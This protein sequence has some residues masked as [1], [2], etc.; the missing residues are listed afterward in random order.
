MSR[1]RVVAVGLTTL[2]IV[3]AV[4]AVARVLSNRRELE[5]FRMAGRQPNVG[6]DE[7]PAGPEV[8]ATP[9]PPAA[10]NVPQIVTRSDRAPSAAEF[11]LISVLTQ[12]GW[13][14]D[15]MDQKFGTDQEGPFVVFPTDFGPI[16]VRPYG[17]SFRAVSYGAEHKS[18]PLAAQEPGISFD[19]VIMHIREAETS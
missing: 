13:P 14:T 17:T 7:T 12:T 9:Q 19:D 8:T 2:G 16:W 1:K 4:A 5:R 11:A 10:A 18:V 6:P 3:F 15:G